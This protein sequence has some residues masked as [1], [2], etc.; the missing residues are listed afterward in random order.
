MSQGDF[1]ICVLLYGDHAGLARRCLAS[2]C[3]NC[4]GLTAKSLRIGM[5]AVGSETEEYVNSLVAAG[6]VSEENL[7]RS[8]TNLHKYPLMR[9]MF[10]GDSQHAPIHTKYVM[11]F[12]DDSFIK[13]PPPNASAHFLQSVEAAMRPQERTAPH[14]LGS[15]YQ[16]RLY[17]QQEDWIKAQW[18]YTG[19]PVVDP[20]RFATGGWWTALMATMWQLNY[21]W[22]SLDHRGGDV[23]LGACMHQQGFLVSNYRGRVAINA[24]DNGAESK[25]K[26]RGFDSQPIGADWQPGQPV[27]PP[28]RGPRSHKP[29]RLSAHLDL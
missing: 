17:G 18:W 3:T 4:P 2:I 23:M 19:K 5:N 22:P 13:P 15:I 29:G 16:I 26:R 12:D 24:D 25:A 1:T 10:Y 27:D 6:V 20:V 8:P 28:P 11:W 14:M 9:R 7:W 21:P